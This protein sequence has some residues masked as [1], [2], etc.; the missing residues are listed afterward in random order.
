MSRFV[1]EWQDVWCPPKPLV[2]LATVE[3]ILSRQSVIHCAESRLVI[4][5]IGRGVV[6]CLCTDDEFVRRDARR[7]ILGRNLAR[8]TSLVGLNSEFVRMIALKSGYLADEDKYFER[9]RVK[10]PME[11]EN[12]PALPIGQ[13]TGEIAHA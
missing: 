7:F 2:G 6:D 9:K 5:V 4:A 3:K 8:W 12:A 1:Y 11:P 10:V 13:H